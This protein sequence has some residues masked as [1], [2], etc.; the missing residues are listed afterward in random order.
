LEDLGTDRSVELKWFLRNEDGRFWAKCEPDNE[1]SV[2]KIV[3]K[4]GRYKF[5]SGC[6]DLRNCVVNPL[7]Y[8]AACEAI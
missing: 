1:R 2:W 4:L 7:A 8:T 6:C 3:G 5:L